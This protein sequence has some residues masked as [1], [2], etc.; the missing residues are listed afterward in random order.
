M[1]RW[2]RV[3]LQRVIKERFGV[4]YQERQRMPKRAAQRG[5]AVF[6]QRLPITPEY[7]RRARRRVR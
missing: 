6:D 5:L 7:R 4:D 2:R 3:D 1:V